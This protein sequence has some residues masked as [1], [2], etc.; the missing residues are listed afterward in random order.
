MALTPQ[1]RYAR[2]LWRMR[3]LGVGSTLTMSITAQASF[4]YLTSA[5]PYDIGTS[6]IVADSQDSGGDYTIDISMSGTGTLTLSGTTGLTG[7]G[8]G[9]DTLSYVGTISAINTA[10]DSAS[11]A[12]YSDETGFMSVTLTNANGE[13]V[14]TTVTVNAYPALAI[15]SFDP[16]DDSTGAA[17][18]VTPV[19]TFNRSVQLG[20][21]NITL[22]SG[23]SAVETFNAATGSGD[24]GGTVITSGSN[25]TITPGTALTDS[26]A[27]AI[28]IA[29]TSIDGADIG[30]GDSFAG[31]ADD[32]T[33]NFTVGTI[34]D[35][36]AVGG[37]SPDVVADFASATE[38]F[39]VGGS[40]STFTSMFDL[41]TTT[42]YPTSLRTMVDSDGLLKWGPHNLV[43]YST[44]MS[45]WGETFLTPTTGQSD[46][47][48]GT[49]AILLTNTGGNSFANS[50]IALT[51][52]T[53]GGVFKF[54]LY[55]KVGTG[56]T[57][58]A[59]GP[60][61]YDDGASARTWF[62][63]STGAVGT[64][65]A[66]HT[67]SITSVGS[68]WYL[69]AVEMDTATDVTGNFYLYTSNAD[70]AFTASAGDSCYVW[71]AHVYRTDLGGMVDVPTDQRR[72]AGAAFATYVPTTTTAKYLHRRG[73]HVYNGSSWVNKGIQIETEARTNL[74]TASDDM[75][76]WTNS[77][78][79]DAKTATGPGG[80]A[81]GATLVTA[82]AGNG[83]I[84]LTVTAAVN[85]YIYS[86]LVKRVTGTGTIEMTVNGGTNWVDIT[87]QINSSVFTAVGTTPGTST[88]NPQVGFR[89]VTSGDEIAVAINQLEQTSGQFSSRIPTNGATVTRAADSLQ[90]PAANMSASTSAMSLQMDGTITYADEGA[91]AQQT[92][93]RWQTDANNYISLDLDTD[94]TDTGQVN[95][96][97]AVGGTLDTVVAAAQY[98][99]GVNVAFNIASRHTSGA[100]NVAK[101]GTAA[102][103][104]T[105][106]AS[107]VDLSARNCELFQDAMGN[108]GQFRQFDADLGDSGIETAST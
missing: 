45:Q 36:Y 85:S 79:T 24:G 19:A 76:G 107:L 104:D 60:A 43:T 42:A 26:T 84:L 27:Y 13:T 31:I 51:L 74:I 56:T 39:R 12:G 25:L 5:S 101:D 61:N 4:F 21:G 80:N 46:P 16:A 97:Q 73:N 44:D 72:A 11:V 47:A 29:S 95:A 83:T 82:T 99:A 100:I 48:G 38:Y 75:S 59:I 18:T 1:Q 6:V 30:T 64:V 93:L 7:S 3:A 71:G 9:T 87:S 10:L 58:I 17:T 20:T 86:A 88:T 94:S 108:I 50:Q 90:I 55:A 66:A 40:D 65:N 37:N 67:A 69:C 92:F 63:I 41:G 23:G 81:N 68:G 2:R 106:P 54:A 103:A 105:T 15:S 57:H 78:T 49:E 22:R 32:T 34:S 28:Q 33:W 96:N 102:T 52:P 8:D 35:T 91:A 77:N 70:N 53:G 14:S 98:T 62:N 89:I